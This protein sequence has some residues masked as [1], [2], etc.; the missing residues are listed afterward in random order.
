MTCKPLISKEATS[1]HRA[2]LHASLDEHRFDDLIELGKEGSFIA[3]NQ[4][5]DQSL[6][7]FTSGGDAQGS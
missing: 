6:A 1:L 5:I 3:K 7:V 4:F 2:T